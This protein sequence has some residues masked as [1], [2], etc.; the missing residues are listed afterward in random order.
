MFERHRLKGGKEQG[1]SEVLTGLDLHHPPCK[2]LIANQAFYAIG[3]LAYN[4]L[5]SLKLLDLPDDAQS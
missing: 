5:I 3:M 1:F 4:V 2:A